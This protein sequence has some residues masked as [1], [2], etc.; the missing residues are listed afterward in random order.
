MNFQRTLHELHKKE[1]VVLLAIQSFSHDT[2][3]GSSLKSVKFL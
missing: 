2:A 3:L 1:E